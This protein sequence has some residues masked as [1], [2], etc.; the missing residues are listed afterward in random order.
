[1]YISKYSKYDNFRI[2]F[3]S[4]NSDCQI[5]RLWPRKQY[6]IPFVCKPESIRLFSNKYI[7]L[8]DEIFSEK[9]M[10]YLFA[11]KLCDLPHVENGRIAPYYYSFKGY[12]F[13]MRKG[14]SLSY[15]CVAGYTTETGTQDGRI[16]CM[17]KGW[18][19]V[20]RCY[21]ELASSFH[22]RL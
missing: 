10:C 12:Y 5:H 14:K 13:P 2:I 15:S 1:M 19:P 17:A 9:C 22:Y 7:L 16:T 8:W 11:D 3:F 18:S 4:F 21:S 20:P 6:F